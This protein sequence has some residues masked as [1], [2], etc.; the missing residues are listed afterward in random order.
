M[1]KLG[2]GCMRLP[3]L[4]KDDQT[5]I[6]LEQFK[7]MVDI[8]MKRGFTYYDTAYVYHNGRSEGA[9]KEALVKRYPREAFTI[10][11]KMPMF[12]VNKEEDLERIFN[13]QLTRLGVDHFDYYWLHALNRTQYVKVQKM[14]AFEFIAQKKKEGKTVHIGFSFH[15]TP[16]VL[17][18][19][20]D[21]H[22][23]VEYV[24]LQLNY[25]D[26]EDTDVRAK[27][28]YDVAVQHGKKVIVMEPVRG[29]K[30]ATLPEESAEV[31]KKLDPQA[32]PA[33]WA[34]RYAASK[35][36][37]IMVLSGMSNIAQV[38]DNTS[39]ME[40]F[41]PLN[42]EEDKAL[43]K[44]KELLK[45]YLSILCTA[46]HYCTPGCP[47]KIAIPEYFE[48]LSENQWN[49]RKKSQEAYQKLVDSGKGKAS[50]CIKCGQCEKACPQHLQ[51][52]K[53]L[54]EV[55]EKIEK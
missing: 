39:Y 3:L 7:K 33:S 54:T 40:D 46:C 53:L 4:N 17:K 12:I 50:A 11:D 14:K 47:K 35:E 23:E 5:S 30:L 25:L 19:I 34:I 24:Q 13:E 10:T 1:K 41:K 45:P 49:G 28:C 29:G 44:A 15:D 32:S 48:I 36:E 2:F 27:E 20:L 9:L 6:D 18:Q 37:V 51:I 26:W 42:E 8:F 16:E 22:P 43:Y 55:V 31:L 21:D 38:E 52:R